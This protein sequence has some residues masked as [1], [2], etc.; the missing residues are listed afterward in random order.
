M[1]WTRAAADVLDAR[2][3]A[4]DRLK[5]AGLNDAP[6]ALPPP[7]ALGLPLG[8]VLRREVVPG[9]WNTQ[10]RLRVGQAVRLATPAGDAAAALVAWSAADP[11]ER[12]NYADTVKLQWTSRLGKGR[13]LFSD[14]GRVLLSITEDLSGAH[15]ALMGGTG[16]QATD[17]VGARNTRDNLILAAG[18]LGLSP[19]DIP[20]LMTF[21]APV[22]VAED[23]SFVWNPTRRPGE[24]VQL[25]A[26]MDLLVAVSNCRHPLDPDPGDPGPLEVTIVTA[27]MAEDDFCRTATAEAR[28]GFDN[29]AVA[30]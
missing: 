14:M 15:D 30:P 4:Y 1:T 6:R 7:S 27:P 22:S 5:A 25:R 10:F 2:R 12:L 17:P 28:R 23:G 20:P 9:G 24:F 21:L 29:N 3:A 16:P 19:R 11:S 13:V 18:K 8:E 26:E